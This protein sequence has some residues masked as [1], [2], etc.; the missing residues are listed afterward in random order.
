MRIQDLQEHLRLIKD[1]IQQES[2]GLSSK[3]EERRALEAEIESKKET[4]DG[5]LADSI[6]IKTEQEGRSSELN[7][8]EAS[9]VSREATLA[10]EREDFESYKSS[11]LSAL[12]AEIESIKQYRG[13]LNTEIAELE[14]KVGD[15]GVLLNRLATQWDDESDLHADKLN[16]FKREIEATEK[17]LGKVTS[18]VML[19]K[20]ELSQLNSEISDATERLNRAVEKNNDYVAS[21]VDRENA[22]AIKERDIDRV[23]Y[24]LRKRYLK[25]TGMNLNI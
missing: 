10:K 18:S 12:D 5:I 16:E 8:R 3:I 17:E 20:R 11:E 25:E 23:I 2:I 13:Q 4:L 24:R 19:A 15:Y 21:L 7:N 6:N 9:F 14:I 1:S 22:I